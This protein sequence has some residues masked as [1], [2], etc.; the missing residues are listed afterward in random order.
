MLLG[1]CN[2]PAL[3]VF[4]LFFFFPRKAEQAGWIQHRASILL[5]DV[6]VGPSGHA[7]YHFFKQWLFPMEL[8]GCVNRVS[9]ALETFY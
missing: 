7:T 2:L 4:C 5:V 1:I 6:A 8:A 3:L 9:N